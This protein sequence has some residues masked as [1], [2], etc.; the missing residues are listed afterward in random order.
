M[1]TLNDIIK[2]LTKNNYPKEFPYKYEIVISLPNDKL[3]KKIKNSLGY[4]G[5]PQFHVDT[6][7]NFIKQVLDDALFYH[8]E[9]QKELLTAKKNNDNEYI[10]IYTRNIKETNKKIK[11]INK[12]ISKEI[13]EI[14]CIIDY[15]LNKPIIFKYFI[16]E[17]ITIGK[18]LYINA[19]MYHELYRIE[20][21]NKSI[22]IWGHFIGDLCYNGYS[23]INIY[24][25]FIVCKFA[26][27]S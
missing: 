17:Q 8:Q 10:K 16:D 22:G 1:T 23:E 5:K 15:P 9:E 2:K 25:K 7:I 20:D 24:N 4:F 12:V 19:H 11:N 21:I 3:N 14:Y 13:K 26:C 18:L 27:D 6:Y